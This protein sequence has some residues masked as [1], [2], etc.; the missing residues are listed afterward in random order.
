MAM[1]QRRGILRF[2]YAAGEVKSTSGVAMKS[3]RNLPSGNLRKLIVLAVLLT[4]LVGIAIAQ[5]P[6]TIVEDSL[7]P[8][9]A[10]EQFKVTFHATGGAPPYRWSVDGKLPEGLN[11]S[12]DGVLSGRPAKSGPF[13]ITVIL[14]DSSHS[15]PGVQKTFK[16]AVAG[17]L[18]LQWLEPP[19]VQDNRIDGSVQ[20]SNGSKDVFDLT[21][22]IVA[23]ADNGRATAI[24]YQRFDLNPGTNNFPIT[25]GNTLPPG[26]YVIHADAIAEIPSRNAILRQRLQTPQPLRIVGEP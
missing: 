23:V 2:F 4:C 21:V 14:G 1:D 17:S 12:H 16:A 20:V 25:F 15:G 7:P 8:L 13:S 9:S 3:S 11:L 24:G 10:G 18:E 5:S 19:A 22:V 6:L 26:P